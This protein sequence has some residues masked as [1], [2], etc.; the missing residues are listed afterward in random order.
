MR[1]SASDIANMPSR[2][3]AAFVNSLS[4]YKSANLVGTTDTEG[5]LNLSIVSS[6]VHLGS[7]PPLM[8]MIIRPGGEERHTLANL[9]ITGHY[10]INHVN[11]TIIEAAHQTAAR[12]P[13]AV[14]EFDATGL[15]AQWWGDFKAP[16]VQEA[17]IKLALQLREH[18]ELTI[19][20][21]HLVIGE[22]LGADLPEAALRDDG[23]VN[24]RAGGTVAL[25]GLDSYY[26]TSLVK[27]MAYAKPDLPPRTV[28]EP[29]AAPSVSTG[30]ILHR[31]LDTQVQCVLST[32]SSGIPR[33]HLMAYAFDPALDKVYLASRAG[34]EKVA[35]MLDHP[36]ISLLWDNRT[37]N[38][39]DHC[40]GIAAM[41]AGSATPTQGWLRARAKFML[42]A[43]NPQLRGLLASADVE[44]FC[45]RIPIYK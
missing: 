7:H 38:T 44:V 21:T 36:D 1:L 26:R 16:L 40:D 42:H 34:T 29:S 11:D 25:S 8:A 22:I 14:S 30:A 10:S 13:Q 15:T 6:V 23:A 24:L 5:N 39:A 35:N 3:R 17:T 31:L 2:R 32:V 41:A 43:R 37:G 45:V 9:L 18:R 12:Y 33:Q 20:G 27:R 4:G 28:P 19:N